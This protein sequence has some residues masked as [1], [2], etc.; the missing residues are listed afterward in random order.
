MKSK[1]AKSRVGQR[2]ISIRAA[3]SFRSISL[4]NPEMAGCLANDIIADRLVSRLCREGGTF[5]DVGAQYGLVFSAALAHERSL[6]I[7]AVEADPEKARLLE[8]TYP[9]VEVLGVAVGETQ[10][11]AKFFLNP[12]A[13]GYNSLVP[14]DRSEKKVIEV[15]IETLD[16]L[17]PEE[18]IDV[19]KID[20]EGAELGALRGGESLLKRSR[21]LIMFEC[22]LPRE[23]ALGY[24]ASKIWKWLNDR[25]FMIYT[26]DRVAH[27]APGLSHDAFLDAQMY[28]FRSHNYFAI[29][30]AC[31]DDIRERAR[32]I[33]G[34]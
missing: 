18:M 31:V 10:G 22:V 26:P 13:S 3:L 25:G 24:S 20:I 27:T 2:L 8:A 32:R 33:L 23:N 14:N 9:D 15:R 30:S 7:F 11:V 4:R 21:P 34:V 6:N 19:I 17:F 28:P 5:V 29:H 12:K 16:S 1:I